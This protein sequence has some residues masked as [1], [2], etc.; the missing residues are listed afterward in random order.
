MTGEHMP[1]SGGHGPRQLGKW[2]RS[3]LKLKRA[4]SVKHEDV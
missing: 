4:L 3:C 2:V 1:L